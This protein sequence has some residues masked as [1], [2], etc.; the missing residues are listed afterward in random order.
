FSCIIALMSASNFFRKTLVLLAL[1]LL[2]AACESRAGEKFVVIVVDEKEL[3][4][5]TQAAT[6]G[7]ALR[8][9]PA[10]LGPLDRVSPDLNEP[11]TRSNR[12]VITRVRED[13][14]VEERVVPFPRTILRDEAVADGTARAI[15]LGVNGHEEVTQKITYQNNVEIARETVA[16]RTIEIPREEIVLLGAK[17]LLKS[18]PLAGMLFYISNGNAWLMFDESAQKRPLT[19]TGDLDGRAF[20]VSPDYEHVLASRRASVGGAIGAGGPLNSL[21]LINTGF[22]G[23]TAASV[24]IEDVLWADWLSDT[25][26]IYSTGERTVGAPGWKAHNDLWLYDFGAHAKQPLLE[27]QSQFAY[28]FWGMTWALSPDRKRLVYASAD[29]LGFIEVASGQRTSLQQFPVYQ[30]QAGWVWT[31]DV[32]WSP[33]MRL[34]AATLHA[35]PPDT[36]LPENAPTFDVWVVNTRSSFAAQ[37]APETGMFANPVWSP[38]GRIAY[39]QAHQPQQ[40]ADSQYDLW[41]MNI[42]GSGKQPI[43]PQQGEHG[44]TN[45]QAAWSA[46]GKQLVV[47]YDGNL[48]LVD[49]DGKRAA[50]LTADGGTTVLR[51]R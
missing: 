15:Q 47:L 48:Y 6:I 8:E 51:W 18:I 35:P 25:Q 1:L 36:P 46:D 50:Q 49:A 30:T 24:G 31:P 20:A 22:V 39:A 7:E 43:F 45:P 38:Q 33:D 9:S 3:R 27:P 16:Q 28:A 26:I 4:Y 10:R 42:D 32:S 12:I 14:I 17:G 41:V 37:L 5:T 11:T 29:E 21:W 34:L 40:S 13:T 23:D 2:L 19:F 44:L